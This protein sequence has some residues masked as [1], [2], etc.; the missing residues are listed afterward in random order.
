MVAELLDTPLYAWLDALRS[1]KTGLAGGSA[2]ALTIAMAAVLTGMAARR[3]DGAWEEAA[4]AAAQAETLYVRAIELVDEDARAFREARV[5]LDDREELPVESR[6]ARLGHALSHAADVPARIAELAADVALLAGEVA[7]S[8]HPDAR[9]DAATAASLAAGAAHGAA[10][11]VEVNLGTAAGDPVV[12][13]A[14]KAATRADDAARNALA[15]S[16]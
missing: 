6:D 11:L 10:H 15:A 7:A 16:G 14:Q 12:T 8:G 3:A 5:A 13:G 1:G 9:A 4:G 2:G